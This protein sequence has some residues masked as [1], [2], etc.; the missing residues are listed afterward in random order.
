M[1]TSSKASK[2]TTKAAKVSIKSTKV[3]KKISNLPPFA[4]L[5]GP[6]MRGNQQYIPEPRTEEQQKTYESQVLIPVNVF[7]KTNALLGPFP[8]LN[9]DPSKLRDFFPTYHKCK[10]IGHAKKLRAST[11]EEPQSSVDEPIDLW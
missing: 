10:P 4:T 9:T 3:P 7:G 5:P 1:A 2:E 8:D 11:T 6:V